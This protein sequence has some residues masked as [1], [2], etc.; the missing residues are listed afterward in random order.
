MKPS[1]FSLSL[2]ITALALVAFFG[3]FVFTTTPK[4]T[5]ALKELQQSS[6]GDI[7]TPSFVD[8]KQERRDIYKE[9]WQ[10]EGLERK[11]IK[12]QSPSSKVIVKEDNGH[13]KMVEELADCKCWMQEKLY[14]ENGALMQELRHLKA[15]KASF[16]Y[17]DHS[18]I[19]NQVFIFRYLAKGDTLPKLEKG[20][21]LLM[22]GNAKVARFKVQD[23][24]Y[25]F[26]VDKLK[27]TFYSNEEKP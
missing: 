16:S 27:A 21:T 22:K 7:A 12:I 4:D 25:N 18:F 24:G 11:M 3:F 26:S 2:Y 17:D 15:Q 13:F 8:V 19:A 23:G 14:K 1:F 10:V 5:L 9:I 6:Q 20:L